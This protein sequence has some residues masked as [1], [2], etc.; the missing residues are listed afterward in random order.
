MQVRLD[1]SWV[2]FVCSKEKNVS[3]LFNITVAFAEISNNDHCCL[4]SVVCLVLFRGWG[5]KSS[6]TV[7]CY[8]HREICMCTKEQAHSPHTHTRT[9]AQHTY[10]N[11]PTRT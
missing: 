2:G 4:D 3:A 11:K 10:T 8:L 1:L 9:R 7:T 6:F 5:E